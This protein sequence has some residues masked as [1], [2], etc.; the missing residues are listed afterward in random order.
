MPSQG[1]QNCRGV[2]PGYRT[3]G[4]VK[5]FEK[6]LSSKVINTNSARGL[7]RQKLFANHVGEQQAHDGDIFVTPITVRAHFDLL[8]KNEKTVLDLLYGS[9][10]NG[11]RKSDPAIYFLSVIAVTPTKFRPV[12]KMGDMLYEHPQNVNLTEILKANIQIKDIQDIERNWMDA[13]NNMDQKSLL[14]KKSEFLKRTLEAWVK[15]QETVNFLIDSS[16]APN[17]TN[18]KAPP[19]GV[20]QLLE[21]KEG[22]FR[23]HMMGKRVNYAA[24]SVISP[25][26]YIETN[27]IGIPPVFAKKLTYPE[28]VTQHNYNQM[29]QCVINGPNQWPGATHIQNEDGSLVSLSAFDDAGRTA[30]ANQLRTPSLQNSHSGSCNR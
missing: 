28:P 3:E 21:K 12:S 13:N 19:P 9:T 7:Q 26:P 30:L 5:I 16:K 14:E 2:S 25:D 24:R 27:E 11:E 4:D 20:R 10:K 22:L 18:G 17:G 6:A 15:L 8:W 29:R 23:K 1:C